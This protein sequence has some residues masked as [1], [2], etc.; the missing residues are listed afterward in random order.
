MRYC[1]FLGLL[2]ALLSLSPWCYAQTTPRVPVDDFIAELQQDRISTAG[3]TV[4]ESELADRKRLI[5]SLCTYIDEHASKEA[6]TLSLSE[7]ASVSTAMQMLG[8]L[9]ATEAVDVLVKHVTYLS[10]L[11][12]IATSR[13]NRISDY[14]AM[15]SLIRI[16]LPAFPSLFSTITTG[17][18]TTHQEIIAYIFVKTL[19]RDEALAY[20]GVKGKLVFDKEKQAHI[21]ELQTMIEQHYSTRVRTL[22]LP[23]HLRP[24]TNTEDNTRPLPRQ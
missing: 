21:T 14:P 5:D 9:Q 2:L 4:V 17:T 1:Y 10:L 22:T 12:A 7:S 3:V 15:E 13:N 16:G 6:G 11:D 18:D 23:F 24:R 19:G 20:L 8:D